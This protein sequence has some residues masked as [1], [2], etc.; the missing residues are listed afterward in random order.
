MTFSFHDNFLVKSLRNKIL[1]YG[2]DTEFGFFVIVREMLF[3]LLKSLELEVDLC[4]LF[5]EK[6]WKN[7][8]EFVMRNA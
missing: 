5:R 4:E 1:D 7:N 6:Q 2:G 3:L 8:A